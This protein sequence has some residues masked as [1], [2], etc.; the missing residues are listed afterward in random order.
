MLARELGLVRVGKL[1]VDGTRLEAN[2]NRHR[3]STREQLEQEA[4]RVE[5]LISELIRRAEAADEAEAGQAETEGLPAEL[6]DGQKRRKAIQ[7]A[8]ERIKQ[9]EAQQQAEKEQLAQSG[10]QSQAKEIRMNL[11]D[12]D[13]GILHPKG[14]GTV[15]GPDWSRSPSGRAHCD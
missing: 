8:L 1:A 13:C 12:P 5:A 7:G 4:A 15:I 9:P 3:F 10:R 14:A 2:A 6:A 11:T